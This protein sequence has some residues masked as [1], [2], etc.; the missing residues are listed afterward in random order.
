M[1]AST[2][3][4]MATSHYTKERKTESWA[5]HNS[6][7]YDYKGNCSKQDGKANHI[8]QV[9]TVKKYPAKHWWKAFRRKSF[10]EKKIGTSILMCCK[11]VLAKL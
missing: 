11:H 1:V 4:P 6:F 5:N 3:Q 9:Q 2:A 8:H 10:A 7:S